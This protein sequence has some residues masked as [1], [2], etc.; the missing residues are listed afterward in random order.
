MGY[1]RD[2]GTYV[3]LIQPTCTSL[4]DVHVGLL[5]ERHMYVIALTD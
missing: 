4:N 3:F 1:F 2:K 5:R